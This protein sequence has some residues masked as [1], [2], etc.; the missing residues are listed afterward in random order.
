MVSWG[1]VVQ[2]ADIK[3]AGFSPIV[4]GVVILQDANTNERHGSPLCGA[5]WSTANWFAV[6]CWAAPAYR[7][8]FKV[9]LAPSTV[10]RIYRRIRGVIYAN[11]LQKWT[12][13][14]SLVEANE[15]MFGFRKAG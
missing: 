15:T 8:R 13:S 5:R 2:T 1:G 7:L 4:V 9:S 11:S 6:S 3:L 12:L 14:G 10:L